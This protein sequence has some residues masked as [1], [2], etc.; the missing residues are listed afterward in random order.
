MG[1]HTIRAVNIGATTYGR[2]PADQPVAVGKSTP[3]PGSESAWLDRLATYRRFLRSPVVDIA[4]PRELS[5]SEHR[6]LS[7]RLSVANMALYRVSRNVDV[8]HDAVLALGR[9][10]SLVRPQRNLCADEDA[11]SDITPCADARRRYIPYTTRALSWHTDGYYETAGGGVRSFILHCV[12]QA[13]EGGGNQFL[14]HEMLYE[15]LRRDRNLDVDVLF[16]DDAYT[17]PANVV[18]GEAVR[19]AVRGAVFSWID[20]ALVMRFSARQRNITWKSEPR[21]LVAVEAIR[22][23]LNHSPLVLSCRLEPGMGII[24]RNVLHRR[25]AFLD[26]R[27]H[28]RLLL[29]AR[30]HD[31]IP[32]AAL[33]GSADDLA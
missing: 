33:S 27:G 7:A 25:D 13:A 21:L 4:D 14:D 19:E 22:Y 17:I 16:A 5:P 18:E 29:R 30:Y 2:R 23:L 24:A 8:D 3:S 11:V 26:G 31:P 9:Q 32:P 12:S 10:F 15:L 1:S 6:A 20:D 28:R